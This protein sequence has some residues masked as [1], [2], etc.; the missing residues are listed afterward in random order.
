MSKR[1][2]RPVTLWSIIEA[3]QRHLEGQGVAGRDLDAAVVS[4]LARAM[5][6][7]PRD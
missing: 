5:A 4:T 6:A 7:G 2:V 3:L 1:T